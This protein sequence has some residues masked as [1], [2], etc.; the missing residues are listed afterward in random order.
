LIHCC[1]N[2]SLP[3][4]IELDLSVGM[5]YMFHSPHNSKLIN[6]AWLGFVDCLR[7]PLFFAFDKNDSKKNLT[8]LITRSLTLEKGN[9]LIYHNTSNM[10]SSWAT[11]LCVIPFAIYLRKK[12][13]QKL[14][15]SSP[16][17]P[18]LRSS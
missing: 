5:R 3:L 18:K 16:A 10:V 17:T 4:E 15:R 1:P 6:E 14:I 8:I 13:G 12:L 11:T 7:W 2:V 9:P